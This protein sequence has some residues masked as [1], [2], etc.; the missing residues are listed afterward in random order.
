MRHY[1]ER[2]INPQFYGRIVNTMVLF[3]ALPN[4]SQYVALKIYLAGK[5]GKKPQVEHLRL[6]PLHGND[7]PGKSCICKLLTHFSN[8]GPKG[9]YLCLVHGPLDISA[10]DVLKWILGRM[11][12]LEGM[13]ACIRQLLIGL[14]LQP[15]NLLMPAPDKTALASFEEKENNDFGGARV[16]DGEEHGEIIMPNPYQATEVILKANWDRE[17]DIWNAAMIAWDINSDGIFD[18]LVNLAELVALLGRPP[19][20]LL[21]KDLAPIPELTLEGLA[22]DITADDKE[23]FLRWLRMALQ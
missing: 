8:K 18:D 12:A 7:H 10:N 4:D 3:L 13:K 22:T 9:Q 23:G 19:P 1:Y 20:K 5:A 2:P 15:N 6:D 16:D 17:V 11:M 14:D 21:S